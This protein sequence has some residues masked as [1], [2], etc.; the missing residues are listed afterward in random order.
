MRKEFYGTVETF[1]GI[2]ITRTI[3]GD[4][5]YLMGWFSDGYRWTDNIID[6]KLYSY[7]SALAIV[8]DL[9]H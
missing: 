9:Q 4:R 7:Y 8:N 3:S 6:A 2:A 1:K 5:K